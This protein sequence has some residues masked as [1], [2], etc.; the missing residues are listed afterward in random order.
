MPCIDIPGGVICT[1]GVRAIHRLIR[2]CPICKRRRRMVEVYPASPY[3]SSTL[4]CCG[5]GDSWCDGELGYRPFQRGW[6]QEARAK[7]RE[8]WASAFRQ[9]PAEYDAWKRAWFE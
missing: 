9:T 4:T 5:C 3:Y 7:A 8:Q 2:H 1:P 6:R